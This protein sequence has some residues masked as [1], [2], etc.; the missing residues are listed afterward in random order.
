[1]EK[2]QLISYANVILQVGLN[3]RRGQRLLIQADV[4][5]QDFVHILTE[6]AYSLGAGAVY[7]DYNDPAVQALYVQH[8]DDA[9]LD[10]YPQWEPDKLQTIID[11]DD[12][13]LRLDSPFS[14]LPA[15]ADRAARAAAA[16]RTALQ[17]YALARLRLQFSCCIA[18]IPNLNWAT[19][20]FPELP[21]EKA[22]D[23]LWNAVVRCCYA[24]LPDPIAFWREKQ[25]QS[26]RRADYLSEM[27]FE[28]LHYVSPKTDLT[29]K[30][31]PTHFWIAGGAATSSG[32]Y[33]LANM[34][35]EE[36]AT[37]PDCRSTEGT[38]YATK[39]LA[40]GGGVIEN[41]WFRF[42]HGNV[43]E[44]GA[45]K[46]L[47]LLE[48]ILNA[49]AGAT[50][51]GEAALVDRTAVIGSFDRLFYNTMYDENAACHVALGQAAPALV[52]AAQGKSMDEQLEMGINFST[53]HVDFMISDAQTDVF[54][55]KNGTEIPLMQAG[56]WVI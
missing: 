31:I 30:L 2:K 8:A 43:V 39:P 21:P 34:P 4:S 38:V 29:V 20:V 14:E 19:I 28:A 9:A 42:E 15:P 47:D 33:F 25:N 11:H 44:Y 41:F 36:C 46:G 51:L 56:L 48:R 6:Q 32:Q 53:I 10:C 54:G 18:M 40:Y 5:A 49:G 52:R 27:Q 1:M 22:L 12:C 45:K 16:K 55:I 17:G 24:D 37:V 3:I 50:A 7:V 35:S 26:K 13:V 23:A